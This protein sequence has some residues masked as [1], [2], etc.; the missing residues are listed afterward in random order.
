MYDL[1]QTNILFYYFAFRCCMVNVVEMKFY[2]L[3][4]LLLHRDSSLSVCDRDSFLMFIL[5]VNH[6][7]RKCGFFFVAFSF[8]FLMK[9]FRPPFMSLS[10]IK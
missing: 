5:T 6:R 2:Y 8:K 1:I 3:F 7:V 4:Y 9:R 10:E